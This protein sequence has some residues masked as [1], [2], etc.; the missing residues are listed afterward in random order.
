MES[1]VVL[2]HMLSNGEISASPAHVQDVLR[3][4]PAKTKHGV[5]AML[6]LIGY[7][8]NMIK[9]HAEIT[10]CL[11][12]LLKKEKP[13]KVKWEQCHTEALNEI[14]RI[15]VSK[16]VLVGP[17]FDGRPF[18]LMTDANLNSVAGVLAQPDDNN[19]ERNIAYY[20][21]KLLPRQKKWSIIELECLAIVECCMKWCEILYG[22]KIIVRTDHRALEFIDSA[23][24]H[25]A[26]IARWRIVLDQFQLEAVNY[27]A[28]TAN[29]N[30]DALTRIEYD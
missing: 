28:G 9:N 7:H 29:A 8:R 10:H 5:R 1:I 23:A 13:D 27:R 25:N 15:L 16:P 3:I 2:G 6:G 19:V 20:S 26:R 12:E 21:R 30:A 11:T 14:K 22:Q 18:Y 4:G 17:K 24:Q